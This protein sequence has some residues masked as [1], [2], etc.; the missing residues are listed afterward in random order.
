MMISIVYIGS[1][2]G[3]PVNTQLGKTDKSRDVHL[4][5]WCPGTVNELLKLMQ[6]HGYLNHPKQTR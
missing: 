3:E 4:M 5:K 1:I 2:G 6:N